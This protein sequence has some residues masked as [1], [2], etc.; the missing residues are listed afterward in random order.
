VP[1]EVARI[2]AIHGGP[3]YDTVSS[4]TAAAPIATAAHCNRRSLSCRM[5]TPNRTVNS[6]LMK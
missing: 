1:N 4:T 5:T 3:P 2:S 6:G